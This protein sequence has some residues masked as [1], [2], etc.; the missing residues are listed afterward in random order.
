MPETDRGARGPE[1]GG[2]GGPVHRPGGRFLIGW[3]ATG[4]LAWTAAGCV[5]GGATVGA[6]G[7]VP[8]YAAF[9]ALAAAGL[10]QASLLR[11]WVPWHGAWRRTALVAGVPGAALTVALL[12]V[13]GPVLGDMS[14]EAR[15]ALATI[16]TAALFAALQWRVL[17]GRLRRASLWA[18]LVLAVVGGGGLGVALAGAPMDDSFLGT[19]QRGPL[20]RAV[21]S[22]IVSAVP[23]SFLGLIY[24]GAGGA[25]MQRLLRGPPHGDHAKGR[26]MGRA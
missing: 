2:T 24:G 15:V 16:A 12:G 18:V 17:R 25:V 9:A 21:V 1:P 14:S 26:K 22:A 23:T 19:R 10:G 7:A 3:L 8:Y 11:R 4:W 5:A 20:T 13:P 6:F